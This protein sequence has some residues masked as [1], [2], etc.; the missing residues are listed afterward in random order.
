M[1][2]DLSLPTRRLRPTARTLV[3]AI[4]PPIAFLVASMLLAVAL[5]QGQ[6][7]RMA[8]DLLPQVEQALDT[9]ALEHAA[10]LTTSEAAPSGT[11]IEIRVGPSDRLS[12]DAS[13]LRV[14]L[15]LRDGA[16]LIVPASGERLL[17]SRQAEA[18]ASGARLWLA[19]TAAAEV[20]PGKRP[21]ATTERVWIG[22]GTRDTLLLA[23]EARSS[24]HRVALGAGVD[25]A[26]LWNRHATLLPVALA[27]AAIAAMLGL[28][29]CRR[30]LALA[31]T[32]AGAISEALGRGEFEG[33]LQAIIELAS[34]RC[35]GAEMLVRWRHPVRGLLLPEHFLGQADDAGLL[36]RITEACFRQVADQ[37]AR[38]DS[39]PEGFMLSVNFSARQL[40]SERDAAAFIAL[41]R[42]GARRWY[43]VIELREGDARDPALVARLVQLQDAGFLIALD[44]FGSAHGGARWLERLPIDLLKIDRPIV[45]TIGTDSV[46][47]P[48]LDAIVR[49]S[50][51][52]GVHLI[53]EGVETRAQANELRA[54][55]VSAAQGHHF[56]AAVPIPAFV[57][58]WLPAR[59]P[60][61][62]D[63]LDPVTRTLTAVRTII[64]RA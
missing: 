27:G 5:T 25:A 51:Q 36:G 6:L 22:G 62:D 45:G 34:G 52:T 57:A 21:P 33:H 44:D 46:T 19:G 49:V 47:R 15:P 2:L 63:E 12:A 18:R 55:G 53:A 13:P 35:I 14:L 58:R 8:A 37:L 54:L 56:G 64:A 30:R 42:P 32:P 3:W 28:A 24:R 61:D 11:P 26:G 16:R 20:A 7:R 39:L 9:L 17:G 41:A 31:G 50:R 40:A 1:A 38:C 60:D 23:A 43:T 10:A 4:A 29:A 59:T 48:V